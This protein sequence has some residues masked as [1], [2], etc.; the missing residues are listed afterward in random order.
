M[1]MKQSLSPRSLP[2]VADVDV[3][4]A[5][6]SL[7]AVAAALSAVDAGATVF[8]AAPHLY[9]GEDLCSTLSLWRSDA[10]CGGPLTNAIFGNHDLTTPLRVKK[11]LEKALGRNRVSFILGTMVTECIRDEEGMPVSM[12]LA[13][14]NGRQAVLAKTFIDATG[15]ALLCESMGAT[16][17]PWTVSHITLSRVTLGGVGASAPLPHTVSLDDQAISYHQHSVDLPIRP[18]TLRSM[19]EM[20]QTARDH[21]FHPHQL[22]GAERSTL[23]IPNPIETETECLGRVQGQNALFVL[24]PQ[25]A[26]QAQIEEPGQWEEI[27][28]RVGKAAAAQAN[29]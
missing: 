25:A 11:T 27:G 12:V 29:V 17:R 7:A 18:V 20:E 14:R 26:D 22:R 13:G 28:R 8:L 3:A 16:R 24:G 5:G 15:G 1:Q 23:S 2:V 19:A 9:L 21:S 10:E 6:G 4:I